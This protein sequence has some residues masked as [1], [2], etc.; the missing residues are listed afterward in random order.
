MV[1]R[2]L[3]MIGSLFVFV[4]RVLPALVFV[5]EMDAVDIVDGYTEMICCSACVNWSR[6]FGVTT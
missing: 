1:R 2:E 6:P 4:F 5:D 3:M